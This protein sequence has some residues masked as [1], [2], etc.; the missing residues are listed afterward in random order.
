MNLELKK[1]WIWCDGQFI[2]WKEA[3]THLLSYSLHYGAAVFE[4]VRAYELNDKQFTIFRLKDH[5]QRLLNSAKIIGIDNIPF[6][7][8]QLEQAQLELVKKNHLTSCYL[9]PLIFSGGETLGLHAK[10][11]STHIMIAAWKWSSY[12]SKSS[13]TQGIRIKVSSFNRISGNSSMTK[14]KATG[15]YINSVLAVREISKL[16]YDEALLLDK[17]GYVAEGSGANFFI[18]RNNILITPDLSNILEGITRDSI[19][20]IAK[21]LGI[22]VI[23]RRITRDETYIADEAFFTGTAAEILPISSIDDRIIG[24]GEVGPITQQLRHEFFSIVKGKNL[25]YSHWLDQL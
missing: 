20:Q 2:P 23:E 7:F 13:E 21:N 22:T 17:E 6:S 1:G 19:I 25:A 18:V 9:R 4:G 16:G 12:V 5:T 15:N 8:Q 11:L 3:N 14:A 24:N 10:N